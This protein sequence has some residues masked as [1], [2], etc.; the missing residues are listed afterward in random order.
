VSDRLYDDNLYRFD[1]PQASYWEATAGD[2]DVHAPVLASDESCDVAI[3]GGGYTGL[4][5]ALHL[6]RDHNIDVRLLEAG[7]IGWGASGRNGGFCC[8][9]GTGVGRQDL[10]KL[11]GL[12]KTREFCRSQVDAVEL[13][14]EIGATEGIEYQAF[15]SAELDVAH[16][17]RAFRRLKDDHEL[18][19]TKLDISAEIFSADECRERFFDSSEQYGALL[20]RPTFGLHPLRY[21]RGL[22]NAAIRRGA[23]LHERSEVLSWEKSDDGSHLISMAGGTL[24]AKKVIFSTNG[25]MPED[26]RPEFHART[27]PVISA[28]IVTRPLT[29]DEK[30]AHSWVTEHPSIN[31]RRILNYFRV[32]PDNRFMFGGRGHTTGHPEGEQ[33]TYGRLEAMLKKIWPGWSSVE[34]EYR[35]HGLIAMT[36]SLVPSIGRLGEDDTVYFGYG[37]HGNGV[38]TATWTGKQLADWIGSGHS[39]VLPEIVQGMGR[40]YPLPRHRL[41]YLRAGIALSSLLDRRG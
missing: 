25:F 3:I 8:M 5:A 27:L 31:S 17:D 9:G 38:N 14:R 24:K 12:E 41:K 23:V 26:L 28:I 39:P 21:C 36:G 7:H 2:I 32:L 19:T 29:E 16:T 40:K 34:V 37:Y 13:V 20:T 35:W 33:E 18:L 1:S 15:G 11:V 22:A 6:A 10:V 4:S 30:A